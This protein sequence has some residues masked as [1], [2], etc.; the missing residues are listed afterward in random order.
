MHNF[1]KTLLTIVLFV[2]LAA[3]FSGVIM[4]VY[5]RGE[6]FY[7]QDMK[8]RNELSGTLDFMVSGASHG[9]TSLIPTILD[10]ELSVD[11]YN[12]SIANGSLR[13]RYT[14]L[15]K[16][17][18]RNPVGTVV[19][20]LSYD[21]LTKTEDERGYEGEFYLFAKLNLSERIR[22]FLK[23]I[24]PLDY[25][26]LY[27]EF[28]DKGLECLKLADQG[29]WTGVNLETDKG[30]SPINEDNPDQ[31]WIADDYSEHYNLYSFS[32]VIDESDMEY[33]NR[34]LDLCE[35]NG[36]NVILVTIPLSETVICEQSNLDVFREWYEEIAKERGIPFVDFNLYRNHWEMFSDEEDFNDNLHLSVEGAEK[37]TKLFSIVYTMIEDDVD[38]SDLFYDSYEELE[39]DAGYAT[40]VN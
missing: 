16:E 8:E 5:F 27:S 11:S 12:L 33:L 13:D 19:I 14:L 20:E 21:A 39:A 15:E 9:M 36:I 37:F 7:Y 3:V 24:S 40:N 1:R 30:Y 2:V 23:V 18:E 10:E 32:E 34:T 35:E 6:N 38:V 25:D 31:S 22:Y 4:A 26:V 28:M 17:M 29:E